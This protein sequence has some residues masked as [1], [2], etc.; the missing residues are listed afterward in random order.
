MTPMEAGPLLAWFSQHRRSFPW[1]TPFPR[2]PY[3]VLVSEVML[4]QTQAS[5]VAELLPRFLQRFP[6]L[7]ALARAGEEEVVAAFAGLGYY[8]RARLL[9]RLAQ[10]VA[11]SGW[12]QK[13]EELAR[14]PGLGR[15]TAAAVAAFAFGALEPPVDGNLCRIAARVFA[16]ELAHGSPALV[17][18]AEELAR[19][20]VA[21][22]PT[23]EVF[24]ALMELGATLCTPREPRCQACPL[25]PHCAGYESGRPAAFPLPKPTR[26]RETPTWVALWV[27][28]HA[29]EVLLRRITGPPLEGLWLP[30]LDRGEGDPHG[31]ATLLA[32]EAG[33]PGHPTMLGTVSHHITH[34]RITVMLFR[35][36]PGFTVRETADGFR[37][38]LPSAFLP[39]S[40]LAAKLAQLARKKPLEDQKP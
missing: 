17:A 10:Q 18:R 5:R 6:N 14:L 24:E 2:D 31:R 8:R 16:L 13:P 22:Q 1:R 19:K 35:A 26:P 9:H 30:P 23:P 32:R 36:E 33:L 4:Q 39:T 40:S 11:A 27:E 3:V 38:F 28:N 20:L 7:R 37:W 25:A 12:P 34:R 29:G 21:E 15:Y